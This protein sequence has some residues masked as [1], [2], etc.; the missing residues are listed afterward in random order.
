M[1][2]GLRTKDKTIEKLKSEM[3]QK[4]NENKDLTD[5]FKEIEIKLKKLEKYFEIEQLKVSK[6]IIISYRKQRHMKQMKQ[7]LNLLN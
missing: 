4:S 2:E 7:L 6:I 3:Q 5:K 1:K